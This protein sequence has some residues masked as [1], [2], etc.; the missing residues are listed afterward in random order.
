VIG[1]PGDS[2]I[3]NARADDWTKK[4]VERLLADNSSKSTEGKSEVDLVDG[5]PYET[6]C[7]NNGFR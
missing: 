7:D 2:I 1:N 3:S 4:I 6:P 5:L